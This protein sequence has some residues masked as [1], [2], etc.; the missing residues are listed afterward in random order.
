[1]TTITSTNWLLDV[2]NQVCMVRILPLLPI[3]DFHYY[4]CVCKLVVF[5]LYQLL[6]YFDW[7]D[8]IQLILISSQKIL[9]CS[10]F[11][12]CAYVVSTK[13]NMNSYLLMTTLR[14]KRKT[15]VFV[16]ENNE[17]YFVH[18]CIQKYKKNVF[19]KEATWMVFPESTLRQTSWMYNSINISAVKIKITSWS[20]STI[21]VPCKL[22]WLTRQVTSL[23]IQKK[24]L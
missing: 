21:W 5:C 2:S 11:F 7:I 14:H 12:L 9:V 4:L 19:M 20:R 8:R 22:C 13:I 1:M 15:N 3:C 24:V 17:K 18:D 23:T 10:T 6:Q 16:Q